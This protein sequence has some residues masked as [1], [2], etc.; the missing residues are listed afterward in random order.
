[1]S[2]LSEREFRRR[3]E[4]LLRANG[5]DPRV[6]DTDEATYQAMVARTRELAP[7]VLPASWTEQRVPGDNLKAW[8]H[9]SGLHVLLSAGPFAGRWWLHVS[10]TA[11]GRVPYYAELCDVKALFVG[12]DRQALQVFP[13]AADHV[14]LHPYCLHLWACLEEDGDGLPA[15]GYGGAI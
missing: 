15:F 5:I 7:K 8:L 14:N 10:C 9:T 3:Q 2:R 13:R 1:M 4:A 12:R 11:P 6:L